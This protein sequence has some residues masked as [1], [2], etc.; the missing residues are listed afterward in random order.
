MISD[1]EKIDFK[2]FLSHEMAHEARMRDMSR[3]L[4]QVGLRVA[5]KQVTAEILLHACR[6]LLCESPGR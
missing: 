2:I 1:I 5:V 6:F 4:A 3:F